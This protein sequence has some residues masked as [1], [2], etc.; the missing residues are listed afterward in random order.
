ERPQRRIGEAL[1]VADDLLG[2]QRDPHQVHAV[3]VERIELLVGRAGPAHPGAAVLVHDRGDGGHEP[4]RRRAPG[5]GL[6]R[7]GPIDAG[8]VDGHLKPSSRVPAERRPNG[9]TG[10]CQVS[11]LSLAAWERRNWADTASSRS[12]GRAAWAS[13]TWASTASTAPSRSKSSIRTSPAMTRRG[14]GSPAR[15]GR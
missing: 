10:D 6:G 4:A 5:G 15:S 1:V 8:P 11:D 9:P 7:R 3:E 12:S 14:A 13:C 2:A